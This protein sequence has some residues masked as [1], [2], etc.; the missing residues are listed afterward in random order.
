M[1]KTGRELTQATKRLALELE[2]IAQH[3]VKMKKAGLTKE[4]M[5]LALDPL[6][7]FSEQLKEEIEE[8][9]NIR[10]GKFKRIENL[11]GIGRMLICVRIAK[12]MRQTD[13]AANLGVKE[14]QVSRDEKNE[15]HGASLEKIQRVMSAL[16]VIISS[17]VKGFK[18]IQV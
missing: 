4:Q 7:S 17:E 2:M 18:I 3:Q 11:E 8:Y 14:S 12:G 15:Y 6:L 5:K 1:I 9:E 13:L 16:G 10:R